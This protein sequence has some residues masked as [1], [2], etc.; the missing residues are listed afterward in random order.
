MLK[1]HEKKSCVFS[2]LLTVHSRKKRSDFKPSPRRLQLSSFSFS[3]F[4]FPE[5]EQVNTAEEED[6]TSAALAHVFSLKV[7][8]AQML[9]KKEEEKNILG[10][11][12]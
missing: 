3:F 1:L 8:S 11:Y 7:G 6:V 5:G 9:K 4:F 10:T 2:P 12:H